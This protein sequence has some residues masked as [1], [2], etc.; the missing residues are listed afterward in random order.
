[1]RSMGGLGQ[2]LPLNKMSTNQRRE[3]RATIVNYSCG[4]IVANIWLV[5]IPSANKSRAFNILG[6]LGRP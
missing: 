4:L 6:Q 3:E 5:E 1:M 2:S